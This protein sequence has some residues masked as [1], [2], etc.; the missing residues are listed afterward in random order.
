MYNLEFSDEQKALVE[1]ARKFTREVVIPRAAE[2]DESSELP[3]EICKQAFELGL[4]NAEVPDVYG[5][6]DLSCLSHCLVME[7]L[8]YGCTGVNVTL[9][10][11][12]LAAMPLLIAG[13]E[14]QKQK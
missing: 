12:N 3:L 8:A 14:E 9:T 7:E 11:N 2:L 5:G 13:T 6:L 10:A 1:T 4:M